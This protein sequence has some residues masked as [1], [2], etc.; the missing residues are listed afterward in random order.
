MFFRNP[1]INTGASKQIQ[2]LTNEICC[3]ISIYHCILF[4][5]VLCNEKGKNFRFSLR[6]ILIETIYFKAQTIPHR[7]RKT[8][9]IA[10]HFISRDVSAGVTSI[11]P[12][13]LRRHFSRLCFIHF[14]L[15]EKCIALQQSR[16]IE[17]E[18]VLRKRISDKS[19]P[20][21]AWFAFL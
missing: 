17:V 8:F 10:L 11:L 18:E 20:A 12:L 1:E 14:M 7:W 6:S 15:S 19:I 21:F 13:S 4:N 3:N 2:R 9:S 5:P 16:N